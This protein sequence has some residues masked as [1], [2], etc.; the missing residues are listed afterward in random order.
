MSFWSDVISQNRTALQ[1][2]FL[3]GAVI[4]WHCTN[5]QFTVTEYIQA[6]CNYPGDWSSEIERINEMKN[7]IIVAAHVFSLG[8]SDSFH[9][10]SFIKLKGDL[11][12]EMDE[13]W[14]DDSSAP[15]WRKK[16]KIGKPIE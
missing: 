5:E 9:V 1:G 12:S 10:V 14:A 13:Y 3:D 16:M 4:R 15:S 7:T 11:I 6:N 2:Y 8:K